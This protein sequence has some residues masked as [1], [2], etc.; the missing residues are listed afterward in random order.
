[1]RFTFAR[2][3]A[4]WFL[5]ALGVMPG[6]LACAAETAAQESAWALVAGGGAMLE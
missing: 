2:L 6:S 1:M 4:L 5:L 3:V